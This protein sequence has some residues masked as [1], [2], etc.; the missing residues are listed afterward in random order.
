MWHEHR[1]Q[2]KVRRQATVDLLSASTFLSP[3]WRQQHCTSHQKGDKSC[4]WEHCNEETSADLLSSA[5]LHCLYRGLCNLMAVHLSKKK[6]LFRKWK[7]KGRKENWTITISTLPKRRETEEMKKHIHGPYY[8]KYTLG[9]IM[10][11]SKL[12][13]YAVVHMVIDGYVQKVFLWNSYLDAAVRQKNILP[14]TLWTDLWELVVLLVGRRR[15]AFP[16]L[17]RRWWL[18]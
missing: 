10:E 18:H 14:S 5:D 6:V 12:V 3:Y 13:L 16:F 15:F 11:R 17:I 7:S 8:P 9:R 1:S 2:Y 4:C